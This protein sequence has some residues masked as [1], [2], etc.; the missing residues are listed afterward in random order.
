[1]SGVW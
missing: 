1:M